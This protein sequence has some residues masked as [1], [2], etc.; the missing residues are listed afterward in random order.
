MWSGIQKDVNPL[1]Q[2]LTGKHGLSPFQ[3][4]TGLFALDYIKHS[5][6]AQ[7]GNS[8]SKNALPVRQH[9]KGVQKVTP[10]Q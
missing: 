3:F 10:S 6:M 9:R 7:Q 4:G 1:T 2:L 5:F 8:P